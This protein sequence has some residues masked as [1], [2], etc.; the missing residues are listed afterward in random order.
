MNK[1]KQFGLLLILILVLVAPYFVFA[2]TIGSELQNAGT[3]GGYNPSVNQYS[4]GIIA[5]TAVSA[6][7]SLLGIIF[8]GLM[9]YAGYNWMTAAGDEG[10]TTTAKDT[11]RRAIIGLVITAGSWAIWKFVAEKFVFGQ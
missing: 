11:I 3:A 10:K 6:L 5:G 2:Q 9:L 7:F 1:L 8:T 4:F